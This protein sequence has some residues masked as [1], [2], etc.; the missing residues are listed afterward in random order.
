MKFKNFFPTFA[1][2][3]VAI[4]MAIST[5]LGDKPNFYPS[6]IGKQIPQFS[7]PLLEGKGVLTSKELKSNSI[8]NLW[9]SW[10]TACFAEHELLKNLAK[11]HKIYGIDS[12]DF[13]AAA[14][15]HLKKHG[16]PF[17]KNAVDPQRRIALA[18]GAQGLPETFIIGKDGIVYFHHRGVLTQRI[19]DEEILSI[20]AELE[21]NP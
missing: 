15:K 12:G 19:V 4:L 18:M 1:F 13:N 9:A 6:M 20:L 21:K 10:C 7:A 8:V 14:I 2:L 11:T 17:Y 3:L 16:N 5:K